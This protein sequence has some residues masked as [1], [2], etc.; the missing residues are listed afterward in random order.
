MNHIGDLQIQSASKSLFILIY[1]RAKA[2]K[3][4]FLRR[5]T[6]LGERRYLSFGFT[7]NLRKMKLMKN[8]IIS[9]PAISANSSTR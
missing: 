2:D 9:S 7:C 8:R 1:Q 6:C 4:Q 5:G 3:K